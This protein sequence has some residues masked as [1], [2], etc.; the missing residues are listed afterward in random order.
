MKACTINSVN[1]ILKSNHNIAAVITDDINENKNIAHKGF[2]YDGMYIT[3]TDINGDNVLIEGW[4]VTSIE[5]V[6]I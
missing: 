1:E 6:A 4:C 3:Y 5:L 2:N